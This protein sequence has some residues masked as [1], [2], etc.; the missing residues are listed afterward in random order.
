MSRHFYVYRD[1]RKDSAGSMPYSAPGCLMNPAGRPAK[2][3]SGPARQCQMIPDLVL[4]I[5][6]LNHSYLVN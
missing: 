1:I 5:L 2:K 3:N 6:E 4:E